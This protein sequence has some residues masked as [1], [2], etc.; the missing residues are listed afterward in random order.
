VVAFASDGLRLTLVGVVVGLP[1]SL[2][3]L[4][5][6]IALWPEVP[7]I[8]VRLVMLIVAISVTAVAGL[9]SWFPASRAAD[10]DPAVILRK[11]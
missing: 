5:Q 2:L 7:D 8:S 4:R 10:V 3:G 1:L 6:L 11:E 9:A